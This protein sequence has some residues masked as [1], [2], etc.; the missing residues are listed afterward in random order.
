MSMRSARAAAP[1][2]LSFVFLAFCLCVAARAARP[3]E[4]P[5]AAT[6][7]GA[8]ESVVAAIAGLGDGD[9][10]IL[11]AP[12]LQ[13]Y[14]AIARHPRKLSVAHVTPGKEPFDE[15]QFDGWKRA[16][17]VPVD[18]PALENGAIRGRVGNADLRVVD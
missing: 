2:A 3:A 13:Y 9:G 4:G 7:D 6:I 14:A 10:V 1:A 18:A 17:P 16:V 11:V 8:E 15:T 12:G 5:P